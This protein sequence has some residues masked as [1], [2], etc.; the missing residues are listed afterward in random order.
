MAAEME[1]SRWANPPQANILKVENIYMT[2][3]L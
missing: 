1:K 3:K 2:V